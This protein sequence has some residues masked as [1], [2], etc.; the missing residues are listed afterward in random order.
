[1]HVSLEIILVLALIAQLT[2]ASAT[3]RSSTSTKL[4][5]GKSHEQEVDSLI[6]LAGGSTATAGYDAL[7]FLSFKSLLH[8]LTCRLT[9]SNS[10]YLYRLQ[11][12]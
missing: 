11:L 9:S 5:D 8:Q 6:N 3:P 2:S 4:I 10:L 7:S 12:L 1:M